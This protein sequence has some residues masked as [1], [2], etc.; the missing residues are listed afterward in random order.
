LNNI[1]SN[2][3][4]LSAG[5]ILL[6]FFSVSCAKVELNKKTYGSNT[7]IARIYIGL[8][9]QTREETFEAT[10]VQSILEKH[11]N[12]VTIEHAKGVYN[13]KSE[14]SLILTII[15]CCRWEIPEKAFRK[16]IDSTVLD[17]RN[18][19]KQESVLVEYITTNGGEAFEVYN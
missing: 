17:L 9:S 18:R 2:N 11:F 16:K 1:L 10:A 7:A 13:G 15:N 3:L 5:A 8:T 19:L 4:I 6:M 14:E 12:G